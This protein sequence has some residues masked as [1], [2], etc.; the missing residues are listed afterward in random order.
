MFKTNLELSSKFVESN[1][2]PSSSKLIY[3]SIRNRSCD[4]KSIGNTLL[5]LYFSTYNSN[6][7]YNLK[8]VSRFS[9]TVTLISE[10]RQRIKHCS[11]SFCMY[12]ILQKVF[13]CSIHFTHLCL[14]IILEHTSSVAAIMNEFHLA[15]CHTNTLLNSLI[16]LNQV[17][18]HY[19]FSQLILLVM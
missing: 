8:S 19:C 3:V 2:T 17:T 16:L 18:L 15:F 7:K 10:S 9:L 4:L 14:C 12:S 13:T 1:T 6:Q 5:Y 11:L